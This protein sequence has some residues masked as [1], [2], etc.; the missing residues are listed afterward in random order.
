MKC[1]VPIRYIS[2]A[3]AFCL[4]VLPAHAA[5]VN[6]DQFSAVVNGSTLF[7]DQ[8]SN[9]TTPSQ[10][11][12][13]Y[14]VTGAFPNGA[15]TNG[16]L[17]LDTAWGGLTANALGVAR[18]ALIVTRLTNI[19][20]SNPT[21]GFSTLNTFA[22]EGV[23]DLGVPTGPLA[24]AYGIR[25]IEAVPLQPVQRLLQLDVAWSETGGAVVRLLIQDFVN[26]TITVLDSMLFA[27]EVGDTQVKLRLEHNSTSNSLV[28]GSYAFGSNGNFDPFSQLNAQGTAM[29]QSSNFLRG[30]FFASAAV[31]P[32]PP[33]LAL[34]GVAMLALTAASR[35]RA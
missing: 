14:S 4:A 13:V 20:P 10:E 29:F 22:L 7:A 32:E 1:S 5:V 21:L 26:D 8:F 27:P 3:W 19:Q 6:I 25:F 12:S 31:V 2:A 17:T 35:R 16:R 33:S 28:F 30:Q 34:I 18:Q 11:P 9:G 15:E 24:N 23:F